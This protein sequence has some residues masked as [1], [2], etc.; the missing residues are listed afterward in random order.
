M[1]QTFTPNA[2]ASPLAQQSPIMT[3]SSLAKYEC[4]QEEKQN[5]ELIA[6]KYELQNDCSK[7]YD[8]LGLIKAEIRAEEI[9]RKNL[10]D[11]ANSKHNMKMTSVRKAFAEKKIELQDSYNQKY[12]EKI[13]PLENQIKQLKKIKESLTNSIENTSNHVHKLTSEAHDAIS[14][15]TENYHINNPLFGLLRVEKTLKQAYE[16]LPDVFEGLPEKLVLEICEILCFEETETEEIDE[17]TDS[18]T[19][20]ETQASRPPYYLYVPTYVIKVHQWIKRFF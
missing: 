10:L 11:E 9:N 3:P 12:I 17:S 20:T 5:E 4:K 8:K 19:E 6:L 13:S 15:Y 7:L 18:M 2:R 14:S 16:E 1:N